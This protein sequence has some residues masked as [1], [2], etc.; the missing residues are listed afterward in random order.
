[1][2]SSSNNVSLDSGY[3]HQGFPDFFLSLGS[4]WGGLLLEKSFV[5]KEGF[6]AAIQVLERV[7]LLSPLKLEA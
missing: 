2:L 5:L 7:L 6:D 3:V 1:M 4:G